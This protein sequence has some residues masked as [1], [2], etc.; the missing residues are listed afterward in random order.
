M[1]VKQA[2]TLAVD[3]VEN[4]LFLDNTT[5]IIWST[6]NALTEFTRLIRGL[7]AWSQGISTIH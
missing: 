2:E 1:P 6:T 7:K 4:A 5:G 3:Q